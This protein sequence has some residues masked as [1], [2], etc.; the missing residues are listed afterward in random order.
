MVF[1]LLSYPGKLNLLSDRTY[2]VLKWL[3]IKMIPGILLVSAH[4]NV[5]SHRCI[6]KEKF[7][8]NGARALHYKV[9]ILSEGVVSMHLPFQFSCPVSSN[10][11]CL[12][13]WMFHRYLKKQHFQKKMKMLLQKVFHS[14][15]TS[16]WTKG[17]HTR[18]LQAVLPKSLLLSAHTWR[19]LFSFYQRNGINEREVAASWKRCMKYCLNCRFTFIS[20]VH[21][22]YRWS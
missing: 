3:T 8:F 5:K 14:L 7:M 1:L 21:I 17:Y 10:F 6:V 12:V 20:Y 11:T 22:I 19:C 16:Y 9:N 15:C 4:K 2:F 18:L 13:V